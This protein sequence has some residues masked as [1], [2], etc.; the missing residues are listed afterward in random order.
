MNM[1]LGRNRNAKH[2]KV[3]RCWYQGAE[4]CAFTA[5]AGLTAPGRGVRPSRDQPLGQR[6]SVSS[7]SVDFRANSWLS[8]RIFKSWHNIKQLHSRLQC[9]SFRRLRI[10]RLF[11][12][13]APRKRRYWLSRRLAQRSEAREFGFTGRPLANASQQA[14]EFPVQPIARIG[15]CESPQQPVS[16]QATRKDR[17]SRFWASF[18]TDRVLRL[19]NLG[20]FLSRRWRTP[21]ARIVMYRT[22]LGRAPRSATPDY[23]FL[24][25]RAPDASSELA[26]AKCA[27]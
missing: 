11:A 23:D 22:P 17:L 18:R 16:P 14:W 5:A 4:K 12:G 19:R 1:R 21:K 10:S 8:Q 24:R 25:F 27:D 15:C 6:P 9:D 20:P 2:N 3:D 13:M 26:D 7:A